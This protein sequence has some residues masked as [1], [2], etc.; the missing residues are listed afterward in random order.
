[1]TSTLELA[2]VCAL[3]AA[4]AVLVLPGFGIRAAFCR[5][6]RTGSGRWTHR[7][8]DEQPTEPRAAALV[9]ALAISLCF[10]TVV[11]GGLLAF[12]E[13]TA[14]RLAVLTG[15]AAIAGLAPFLRWCNVGLSQLVGHVVLVV[16]LAA[17]VSLSVFGGGYR[18]AHSYQWFYWGLGR[19]LSTAQGIPDH[20]WEWG[21]AVRW[22]PDYLNFN[23]LG[24]AYIGLMHL[25]PDP[26]A[27]A[28]W[29]LPL[30]LSA[31]AMTFLVFRLWFSFFP[32]AVSTAVLSAAYLYIDKLGN[33]SPE[34]L[35]MTFGLVS[36]WLMVQGLRS[37]RKPWVLLAFVTI[38]L[39][40]SIHAIAATIFG[41]WL[42]AAVVV[43]LNG[44]AAANS[45]RLPDLL[46]GAALG[47]FV[48]VAL[49]LSLQGRPSPLGDVQHPTLIGDVDPTY[50]FIQYS[51]GHF[52]TP[53]DNSDF[54]GLITSPWRGVDLTSPPWS[55]VALLV[56]AAVLG[57]FVW[58]PGR[59]AAGVVTA[60]IFASLA[61]SAVVWFQLR[62]DTYVPQHTGNTRIMQYVPLVYAFGLGAAL[63][64]AGKLLARWSIK[65]TSPGVR[66]AA[67]YA[68]I[69]AVIAGCAPTTLHVMASLP[70]ISPEGSRVFAEL[71]R[72]A[73]TDAVVVSN[74]ATRG[75][76]EFFT[77]LE[78]PL[79]GRQPLI[80]ERA[81]LTSATAYLRRM[82]EFLVDP[83]PQELERKLGATWLILAWKS[84]DLGTGLYY[85]RPVKD[86]A[87]R[88]GLEVVWKQSGVSLLHAT[89]G[90]SA[91]T[92]VGPAK[93]LWAKFTI[94]LFTLFLLWG[95]MTVWWRT[96]S[97]SHSAEYT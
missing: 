40:V 83:D 82:H 3:P 68:L 97:R 92:S 34:A 96:Q 46:A 10:A 5:L 88:A 74:V 81:T 64:L 66:S 52:S 72:V 8:V 94:S 17:P 13:F 67:V 77:G 58:R 59:A 32:A 48:V 71:G 29:R 35:G 19:Q 95:A 21:R 56:V 84:R 41:M 15:L 50:R 93:V 80:E 47:G 75:T 24:Q 11:G 2:A 27:V 7:D 51:N 79:E 60:L 90:A 89:G 78:N 16:A 86:F 37:G 42:V 26:T 57:V 53:V 25:F 9:L 91:A 18:P 6:A 73:S 30:A 1:M 54:R 65:F 44:G 69:V 23:I 85:G 62:Y 76:V 45:R 33:N 61:G 4:A 43:E 39:T 36:V 87:R 31:L 49:G 20:V 63:E 14:T 70:S 38:A 28:V 22:Q 12:G 55:L